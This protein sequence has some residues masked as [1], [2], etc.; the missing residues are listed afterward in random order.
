MTA[1]LLLAAAALCAAITPVSPVTGYAE[2][3]GGVDALRDPGHTLTIEQ[4]ARGSACSQF[5]PATTYPR[6]GWTQDGVWLRFAL[7]PAG[8]PTDYRLLVSFAELDH[9]CVY[10]PAGGA[11][12]PSCSGLERADADPSTVWSAGYLFRPPADFDATRPVYLYA[13]SHMLLK[14]PLAFGTADAILRHDHTAQF[15]WGGYYGVLF[16][17][18]LLALLTW[19]GLRERATLYYALHLAAYTLAIAAWQGRLVEWGWPAWKS[20]RLPPLFSALFLAWGAR[21]YQRFLETAQYAPRLH[22]VLRHTTTVTIIPVAIALV[23]PQLGVRLLGAVSLPWLAAV[24]GATFIRV[25]HGFAPAIWVLVAMGLL[26]VTVLLKGLEAVGL[27]VVDP[28]TSTTIARISAL[29][30]AG[31]LSLAMALQM[32]QVIAERDRAAR[33][34]TT[35]REMALFKARF[36]EL[37]NLPN[38]AKFRDDLTDRI[39]KAGVTRALA[40]ITMGLDHF[41]DINHALGHDAGDNVLHELA[42]RLR[43]TLGEN[44]L[45]ARIGPDVFGVV[46]QLPQSDRPPLELIADRCWELQL[47]IHEPLAVGGG[48]HVSTSIGVATYPHHGMSADL[49]LRH[50]DVALYKAKE[51]GGSALE[52]FRAEML[53]T[54]SEHVAV[55]KNLRSALDSGEIQLHYQP[56]VSLTDGSLLGAEALLRWKQADGT[57]VAPDVFIPIAEATDLIGELSDWVLHRACRQIADWQ[58]RGVAVPRVSVNL[59]PKLFAAGDLAR[60]IEWAVAASGITGEALGVELTESALVRDIDAA[61]IAIRELRALDVSV[62]IDDFGVGYSSL[63]YLRALPLNLLK[64]DRSFLRGVPD[65]R[66]AVGV[67]GAMIAMAHELSLR[68]I[69]EGIETQTQLDWLVARGVRAGQGFLFSKALAAAD[70]EAWMA[71]RPGARTAA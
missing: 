20:D 15:G 64:I 28:D 65:E 44:D 29:V 24:I 7:H 36:D 43:R 61:V 32:R 30:P 69:A 35:H 57:H 16:T 66:E 38:R 11:W 67:I 37:T 31:V 42:A 23:D 22:Q 5:A 33:L 10:W 51:V 56:I 6:F 34:A 54:A 50:S 62:A 14:V 53:Q 3:T 60:R 59:S 21:F 27:P 39:A 19:L 13:E 71:A 55:A 41:R 70:L 45:I 17:A 1:S 18:V 12:T 8:P 52:V 46:I 40:V 68:V 25:Q 4:V 58:R 26:L 48:V 9:V 47:R 2:I 49:L 63:H